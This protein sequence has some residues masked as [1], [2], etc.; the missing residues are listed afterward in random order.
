MRLTKTTITSLALCGVSTAAFG[1]ATDASTLDP[2]K[3]LWE[4]SAAVGLTLTRGNSKT[5][6]VNGN[7]QTARKW[8]KNELNIGADATYGEADDVKN[9]ESYGGYIQ[10]NRLFTDRIFGY[11]RFTGLHDG[12]AD[13]DYRFTVSPG[14]GYYFIKNEKTNLRGEVGPGYVFE[15]LGGE[16]DNYFTIRF[17]ERLDHKFNDWAKLWQSVEFLPKVED[18]GQ[19]IVNAEIGIEATISK[20]LKQR[21]YLQDTYNSR[22]AEGRE[23]NDLKLVAAI[24]YTF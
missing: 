17:A 21:T 2:K 1:Q 12:V 11:A 23:H 9:A 24:A 5:F 19:Y 14:A 15:K 22:P 10:Y 6:L 8:D 16:E 3:P 7:L 18:W 20:H 13:I 4:T